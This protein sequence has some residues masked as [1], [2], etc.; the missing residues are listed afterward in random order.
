MIGASAFQARGF[1]YCCSVGTRAAGLDP[2][3]GSAGLALFGAICWFSL[4]FG[5][6]GMPAGDSIPLPL[7]PEP[8]PSTAEPVPG[9][10]VGTRAAGL[11]PAAGSA[12]FPTP[13]AGCW[14]SFVVGSDGLPAGDC[15]AATLAPN[16]T[17]RAASKDV[18]VFV[19]M[20]ASF[21]LFVV[22]PIGNAADPWRFR[23]ASSWRP[24]VGLS[25]GRLICS[26]RVRNSRLGILE[27]HEYPSDLGRH[28]LIVLVV[29]STQSRS[30]RSCHFF[31]EFSLHFSSPS[32]RLLLPDAGR[33]TALL[34]TQQRVPRDSSS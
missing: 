13:G 15:A 9:G 34:V 5:S 1:G 17:A 19:G 12:G 4:V 16:A 14:F 26:A 21:L 20:D 22:L 33:S 10:E 6:A 27:A 2:A 3:S 8:A 30:K 18:V 25:A 11:E 23:S 24:V 28:I 32:R 29:N 31:S 7:A